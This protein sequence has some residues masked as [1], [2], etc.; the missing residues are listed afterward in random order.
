[1]I[2]ET[3]FVRAMGLPKKRL[4][5]INNKEMIAQKDLWMFNTILVH[6]ARTWERIRLEQPNQEMPLDNIQ[7]VDEIVLIADEIFLSD[8]IQKFLNASEEEKSNDFWE[9]NTTEGF[10][11]SYIEA[12]ADERIRR[13]YL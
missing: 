12:V 2:F 1:M 5:P 8:V 7:S 6:V 4:E 11:D 9:K 13:G 10:S 3:D